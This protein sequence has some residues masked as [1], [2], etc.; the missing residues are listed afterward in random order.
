PGWACT[1]CL[2]PR[3]AAQPAR[4]RPAHGPAAR[5]VPLPRTCAGLAAREEGAGAVGPRPGRGG[6]APARAR[7]AG[8]REAEARRGARGRAPEAAAGGR[9]APAGARGGEA[10]AAPRGGGEGGAG[11]GGEAPEGGAGAQRLAG[12]AAEAVRGL[13]GLRQVHPL[14]RQ[15]LL[16][17]AVPGALR[18]LGCRGGLRPRSAGVP[19]VRRLRPERARQ[20]C[21]GLG[22]VPRLRR[23]GHGDPEGGAGAAVAEGTACAAQGHEQREAA[24]GRV[25]G[26]C[27]IAQPA[28]RRQLSHSQAAATC[29]AISQLNGVRDRS[30]RRSSVV[31][32]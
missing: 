15:G 19:G 16:L 7:G 32:P 28:G 2:S 30:S 3:W 12:Q 27:S 9:A 11:A 18:G 21:A 20:A 14:R 17:R 31:S 10:G 25:H 6:E 4:R 13:P 29:R 8:G 1:A 23:R 24:F 26:L 22:Q 5:A